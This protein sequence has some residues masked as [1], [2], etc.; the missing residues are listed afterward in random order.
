MLVLARKQ[1]QTVVIGDRIKIRRVVPGDRH[2]QEQRGEAADRRSLHGGAMYHRPT[3]S[4]RTTTGWVPLPIH[5]DG[6]RWLPRM[7]AT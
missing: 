6:C 1:G 7:A 3:R 5:P 2:R 4:N